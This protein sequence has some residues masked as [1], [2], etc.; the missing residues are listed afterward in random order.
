M[1]ETFL[2]SAAKQ[3]NVRELLNEGKGKKIQKDQNS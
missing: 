2:E 3:Y 1:A